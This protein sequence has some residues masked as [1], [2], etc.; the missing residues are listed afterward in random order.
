MEEDVLPVTFE[1]LILQAQKLARNPDTF[2]GF[3]AWYK[4][5][6]TRHP[7]YT[8]SRP[9]SSKVFGQREEVGKKRS[10]NNHRN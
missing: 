3:Q 8:T 7:R 10:K 9:P 5:F 4:G 1:E 2:A 6:Y